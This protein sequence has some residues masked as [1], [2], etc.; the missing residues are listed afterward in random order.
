MYPVLLKTPFFT[1][2]TYGFFIAIAF[3]ISLKVVIYRAKKV[4]IEDEIIYDLSLIILI[5]GI[6]GA[7]ILEGLINFSFYIYN[8]VEIF[9]I[10][11]GGLVFYGGFVAAVLGVI[12]F[13]FKKRLNLGRI[14]DLYA[15]VIALG[16]S[17]GRIGCFFAGCCYG[18]VSSSCLGITFSNPYSL[19]PLGIRMHPVQ[20]YSS[21]GNFI[22][23]LFLLQIEKHKHYKGQI[24]L[25][26]II[27]Y[28]FFRFF[29]EFFRGD[30]R[31]PMLFGFSV[32]QM[33][34]V[35]F[36]CLGLIVH[37][38][39]KNNQKIEKIIG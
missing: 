31:G 15:P 18:K 10:W 29:I 8:P 12:I 26:Y 38:K 4:G 25:F 16:H 20:L 9:K 17:I 6:I 11:K 23:F 35:L 24:F 30:E 28:A 22:I 14:A 5:S 34:A 33:I 39:L 19:A 3:L 27:S 37:Y 36:L 7:R 32:F 13:I 1:I 21:V 2:H